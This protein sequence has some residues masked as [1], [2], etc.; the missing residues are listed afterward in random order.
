MSLRKI[1]EDYCIKIVEVKHGTLD[2][3]FEMQIVYD[4][5][6]PAKMIQSKP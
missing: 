4:K 3:V 1:N 6:M 2:Q 5:C